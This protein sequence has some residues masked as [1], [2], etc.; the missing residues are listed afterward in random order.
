MQSPPFSSGR[1]PDPDTQHTPSPVGRHQSILAL[2]LVSL[3]ITPC[4]HGEESTT[5]S[6]LQTI[7]V[8]ATGTPQPIQDVQA[9]VQVIGQDELQRH[10]AHSLTEILRSA[11]GVQASS[12]G[13][14][15][16]ISIRGFNTNQS[17]ILLNGQRRTNNYSS[18]NPNQISTFDIDR[19]E[20]IRG[21]MS[22]LY[23]SD[24]LGGVVNIITRQPGKHP[25]IRAQITAGAAREGRETLQGGLHADF[26]DSTLGHSLTIDQ[27]YRNLL[28]YDSST[29]DDSGRLINRSAALRGRWTPN[30]AQSLGW[31]IEHYDRKSDRDAYA[32]IRQGQS[33]RPTYR[34]VPYNSYENE[35]RNF[36]GLD[37]RHAIGT[38]QLKGRTSYGRSYGNTNRSYP[39]IPQEDSLHKQYQ[40]DLLYSLPLADTHQITLGGGYN[41]DELDVTINTGSAT[42]TN[43]FALLQDEWQINDQWVLVAGFRY[44]HFNHFESALTPRASLGWSNDAWH[45]RVS[46]GEGFRAPSLL[47]QYANFARG[48]G[49]SLIQGNPNLQPE[50]SR[51]WELAAGWD[52]NTFKF[53]AALHQSNLDDLIISAMTGTRPLGGNRNQSIYTYQNVE[54]ARIR[55]LELTTAWK[56]SQNLSFRAGYDWLDAKDTQT[57]L[58]LE[59]RARHTLRLETLYTQSST[60]LTLRLWHIGDYYSRPS[61]CRINCQAYNSSKTQTD[62][63]IRH[64]LN[65]Q[66][67]LFAGIDNLFNERDPDNYIST[68]SN[69]TGGAYTDPDTRYFYLGTRLTF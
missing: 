69:N 34:E 50:K 16:S 28:R 10:S 17:L 7:V 45:A 60:T 8:T 39:E 55:G 11:T 46:Y 57:N 3:A 52:Y 30:T 42:R 19:I 18:S 4:A 35:R 1:S 48:G 20:I 59:G 64:S 24:A 23:G 36:Y 43:R 33:A 26:G 44:D 27:E 58:R 21:P 51:S 32:L 12:S 6:E 41:R 29:H 2:L 13:S 68:G 47:E 66:L 49:S 38:G 53:Q 37:Y 56:A 67:E 14:T 31:N 22:S 40:T 5:P 9:S 63:N 15:G 65:T 62:L 54:K 61:G 25:G